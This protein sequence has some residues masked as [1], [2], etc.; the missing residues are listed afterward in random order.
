MGCQ[1]LCHPWQKMKVDFLF[2]AENVYAQIYAIE[3]INNKI[4]VF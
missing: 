3:V 1:Y 4:N 2:N